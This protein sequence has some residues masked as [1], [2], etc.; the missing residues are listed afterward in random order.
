MIA[1]T[2][3]ITMRVA[4]IVIRMCTPIMNANANIEQKNN[5]N[6]DAITNPAASGITSIGNIAHIA[7]AIT[8][9]HMHDLAI[10]HGGQN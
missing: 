3:T 2:T 5:N 6:T 8:S 10:I 9:S 1:T 4:I 7:Y